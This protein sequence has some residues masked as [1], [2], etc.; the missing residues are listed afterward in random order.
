M[1]NLMRA[2]I[3]GGAGF[4]GSHLADRLISDNHYVVCVDN[5]FLGKMENIRHLMNDERFKFYNADLGCLEKVDEIFKAEN[6]DY[7]FHMAANSD[8]QA[9][10]K[11]PGI[12]LK[13]TFLT[14]YNVLECM[15]RYDVK[16]LFFPST[17]AVYGD[18]AGIVLTEKSAN[19][20]PV[21]YYGAAKLSSE[22]FIHAFC[23]MNGISALVFRFP[24]VLGSRLTHG[25]VYDFVNKLRANSAQLHILGDGEQSKPYLHVKDL[26]DGIVLLADS[27]A[28]GVEIYNIGVETETRVTKIAEIVCSTMKLADVSFVYS[29]GK[30][31]WKGD[32]PNFKYSMEKIYKKGWKAT[33][34]SDEAVAEAARE[35][36]LCTQ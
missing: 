13:N 2:L 36:I 31:G 3:T 15:R 24:N 11:S 18:K 30:V 29:G 28:E 12:E 5:L 35:H 17:S 6:I 9:S 19:L 8:I 16:K 26:V 34:T 23:S 21:S 10:S 27:V 14:T 32:V 1:F 25:V 22:A 20:Q 7:I 33:M 4:I